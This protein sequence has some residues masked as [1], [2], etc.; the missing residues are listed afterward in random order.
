MSRETSTGKQFE[1]VIELVIS[2]SCLKNKLGRRAQTYVGPKPGGGK[3]IVDWELWKI[4]DESLRALLSC[5]VQNSGG[6]AEE[7]I[8]YEVLKLLHTMNHDS[9]Y[10]FGW[11]VLGGGGW[12]PGLLDYYLNDLSKHLPEMNGRV[13]ILRTDDLI[14][15][16]LIIPGSAIALTSDHDTHSSQNLF[17]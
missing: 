12:N 6:T 3:H 11:I 7:K 17:Q 2:R 1:D 14:S 15:T 13:K 5:K 10:R 4:E 8:P 16:D 9:R